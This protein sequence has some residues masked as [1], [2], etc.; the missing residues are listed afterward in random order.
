LLLSRLSRNT[1]SPHFRFAKTKYK[2]DTW[3]WHNLSFAGWAGGCYSRH[4]AVWAPIEESGV[5]SGI[6]PH[7]VSG[8]WVFGRGGN[9][10]MHYAVPMDWPTSSLAHSLP[11]LLHLSLCHEPTNRHRHCRFD[12][13]MPSPSTHSSLHIPFFRPSMSPPLHTRCMPAPFHPYAFSPSA[14]STSP[15]LPPPNLALTFA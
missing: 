13:S 4:N 9:Q 14:S 6:S 3:T 10:G 2:C 15:L 11:H 7:A 8:D 12:S 5:T 1:N